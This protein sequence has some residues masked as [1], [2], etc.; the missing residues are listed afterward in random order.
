MREMEFILISDFCS[1]HNVSPSLCRELGEYGLVHLVE[2]HNR[3]YIPLE[4]MPKMEKIIRLHLELEINL[5]GIQVIEHLLSKIEGL[6]A[7]NGRLRQRLALY[8]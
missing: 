5:E 4:E 3:V 7:E 6:Q 1:N 8:E 2:R